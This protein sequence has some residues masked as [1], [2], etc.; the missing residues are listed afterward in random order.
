MHKG[1]ILLFGISFF[2][3][4]HSDDVI[5]VGDEINALEK[6]SGKAGLKKGQ[7]SC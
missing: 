5:V 4:L 3:N 1:S 7:N 2:D 6:D